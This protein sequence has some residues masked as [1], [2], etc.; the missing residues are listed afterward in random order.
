MKLR[1]WLVDDELFLDEVLRRQHN[2]GC[3]VSYGDDVPNIVPRAME[4]D[5][6]FSGRLKKGDEIIIVLC[7][8]PNEGTVLGWGLPGEYTRALRS[9]DRPVEE[10]R[11]LV[12]APLFFEDISPEERR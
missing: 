12:N 4:R 3:S 5:E 1:V 2:F 7:D 11:R 10:R 8:Y 9:F 6:E